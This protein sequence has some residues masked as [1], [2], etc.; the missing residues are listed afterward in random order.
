MRQVVVI[1]GGETF[2]SKEEY[3]TWLR[4]QVVE[5]DRNKPKR[6]K[7]NL[8]TDLGEGYEVITPSMPNAFD[9]K[10]AEW[11]IWFEKYLPLLD[12]TLIFVGH[13]LGGIFLAKYLAENTIGKR[14]LGTFLIAAPFSSEGAPYSLADF[15][16]PSSLERLAAQSERVHLFHST[17]DPVVPFSDLAKYQAQLPY[18]RVSIFGDRDHFSQEAF[19]ELIEAIKELG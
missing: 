14:V 16:L 6:W 15:E 5:L 1:H 7:S 2:D 13:S 4:A 9:A 3:L 8:Q 11:K 18:A 10:Y 12:D 17:D 19:P